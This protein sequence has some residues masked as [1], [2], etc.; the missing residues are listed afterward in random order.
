MP[1]PENV[2]F[3]AVLQAEHRIQIPVEVRWRYKLKPGEILSVKIYPLDRF[4]PFA[5][6]E[7]FH[8][9]LQKS[10]R[11]AV[12]WEIVAKHELKPGILL[13]VTLF[14]DKTAKPRF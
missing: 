9:R 11:I 13:A 12:P 7:K 1:L 3:N 14:A 10:G 6:A 5:S 4:L 2:E 8:A